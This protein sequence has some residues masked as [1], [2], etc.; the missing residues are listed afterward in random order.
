SSDAEERRQAT[1]QLGRLPLDRVLPL[2]IRALGDEDW[3]VRKEA[4]IAARVFAGEHALHAALIEV[5]AGGD[6]VGLRNAA[7]EV[8]AAAGHAATAALAQALPTLDADGRKLVVETL[9]R[10]RDPASIVTFEAALADADDNVRQGAVEA[11]AGLG[12][13]SPD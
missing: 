8:L 5:L 3:R 1:A 4:T 2:L 13:L 6:N 12:S 10:G 7:V 11:I 9:G